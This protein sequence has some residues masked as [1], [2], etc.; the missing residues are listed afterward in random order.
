MFVDKYPL[1]KCFSEK[2][3]H[4]FLCLGRLSTFLRQSEKNNRMKIGEVIHRKT[5]LLSGFRHFFRFFWKNDRLSTCDLSTKKRKYRWTTPIYPLFWWIS[6]GKPPLYIFIILCFDIVRQ[7]F[8]Y[9][10]NGVKVWLS[11]MDLALWITLIKGM[12]C[13]YAHELACA[14]NFRLCS[15][16]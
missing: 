1:F 7:A 11:T 10:D 12:N 6:G 3:I 5:P 4:I 2:F 15:M 13:A 16:N 8:I 9:F 14:M